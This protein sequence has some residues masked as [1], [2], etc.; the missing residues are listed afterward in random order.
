MGCGCSPEPLPPN[1]ERR[2][3]IPPNRD[4]NDSQ[5]LSG[6]LGSL[7]PHSNLHLLCWYTVQ[8][9][10]LRFMSLHLGNYSF[11]VFFD[12]FFFPFNLFSFSVILINLILNLLR[13]GQ[14]NLFFKEQYSKPG[15]G[16]SC[17]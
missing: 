6:S 14:A 11:V 16:G 15:S 8:L 9:F 1:L 7:T 10:S 13:E 17:L 5:L 2:Q 4:H 12:N 3:R